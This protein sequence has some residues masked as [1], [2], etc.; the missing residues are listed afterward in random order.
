MAEA[1]RHHESAR[2]G[3]LQ[4]ALTCGG[5]GGSREEHMPAMG[6]RAASCRC[7]ASSSAA[8]MSFDGA[9]I[10]QRRS[11]AESGTGAG[12]WQMAD[13]SWQDDPQRA[14]TV[15]VAMQ[16]CNRWPAAPAD[17][18]LL[19]PGGAAR[20][21]QDGQAQ[22]QPQEKIP[23]GSGRFRALGPL[24]LRGRCTLD[25][26]CSSWLARRAFASS[27]P[28]PRGSTENGQAEGL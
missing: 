10:F 12:R 23:V 8:A 14:A 15:Y 19:E 20:L 11:R 22:L 9:E 16:Q 13:G 18:Q 21:E 24:I 5:E 17:K 26:A 27:T 1:W 2:G 28:R 4:H 25:C 3:C 7:R 6:A